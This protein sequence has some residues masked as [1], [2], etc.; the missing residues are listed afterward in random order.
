VTTILDVAKLAD[1]SIAT[2][3][4]VL[5]GDPAVRLR[6]R[7]LVQAAIE[8]LD[9][10]PNAAARSLRLARSQTLG[11]VMRDL[12]NPVYIG[13]LHG[14][15]EV[16]RAHGFALF[17]CDGG[18]D[19]AVEDL[20]LEQLFQRR[21]DGVILYSIGDPSP[22]LARFEARNTPVVAMG[23][24]ANRSNIP[25]VLVNERAATVAAVQRLLALG[26]TRIALVNKDSPPGRFWYRSEPIRREMA[27]AGLTFDPSLI[28]DARTGEECRQATHALLARPD[29]PTAIIVATHFLT[30][31]VLQSIQEKG[32]RLPHDLSL[33]A[34]GDSAWTAAYQPPITVVH[35][36]YE[37]W[38]RETAALLLH[39]IHAPHEPFERLTLEAQFIER[40]TLAPAPVSA[41]AAT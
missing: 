14:I 7:R 27:E 12:A 5:N 23:P 3:S 37:A 8:Q 20:H 28:V 34:Y 25:A 17:L 35:T 13:V 38:G 16:V 21:V 22:A 33:I 26:H 39:L 41:P 30:P 19:P 11:L 9:Y 18:D 1:V 31:Y 32:L 10:H 2:V 29:P 24:A 6:T 15:E 40:A 36:D 4:R